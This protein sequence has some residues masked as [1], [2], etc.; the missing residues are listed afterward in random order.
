[1]LKIVAARLKDPP[2]IEVVC[3]FFF[4]PLAG[5]DPLLV[6]K[7][8]SEHKEKDGYRE[9]QLHPAVSDRPGLSVSD[10][11]GPLRCWL[12]KE[13]DDYVL[14]I[15][16]DRFYFNWRK[17]EGGYPHFTDRNGSE[18]VLTKSLREFDQFAR[19]CA[20]EPA[21]KQTPKP[22][23]FELA[24]IDLLVSPAH[25]KDY[26]DLA[27]VVPMLGKLPK[28]TDEPTVNLSLVGQRDGYQV[29]FGLTNVVLA[30]DMSPA[31][32]IETRVTASASPDPRATLASMNA[33]ANDVFFGTVSKNEFHRFGGEIE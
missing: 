7:Y 18:G 5:L 27:T 9:R 32:K 25:W 33:S 12:I 4:A 16:P 22:L 28:I 6:G 3:G 14:Q 26:A 13:T 10:N 23:R 20:S 11:L 8:W 17:R 24:K 31:L 19:F 29:Q 15:Q 30:A 21:L 2:I 1:M